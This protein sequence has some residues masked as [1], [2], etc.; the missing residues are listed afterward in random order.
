[1]LGKPAARI[2]GPS[3]GSAEPLDPSLSP[4]P[5]RDEI[6]AQLARILESRIFLQSER[7]RR[8]LR[9]A[10]DLALAGETERIKEYTLGRDV[11]DRDAS[12]DPR[13]DSIVRV[14]ARRLRRKLDEYYRE[15]GAH[16]PVRIEIHQGSYVPLFRYA[17]ATGPTLLPFP[18][19]HARPLNPRTVAVLPFRNLSPDSAQEFFCDG[20]TEEILNTLATIAELNVVARTSVFHFKGVAAD[21]REIGGQLGAGTVIEGSVRSAG[22][23]LR[24][25]AQAIDAGSGVA[26]WSGSF[27]REVTDIFAV[28]DEI[29]R[30]IADSLRVSLGPAH[31]T[32]AR[33]PQ[34]VEAYSAY[35]KGC[36]FWNQVSREGVEAALNEFKRS[37]VLFPDYAP[38]HVGLANAY[39]NLTFWGLLPLGTER[40]KQSALEALRLDQGMSGAY[41]TLGVVSCCESDWE[42]GASLL[43]KA[44]ELQPSNMIARR[45]YAIYLMCFERFAEAQAV[46]ERALELDPLSPYSFYNQGLN[47]YFQ[48]Q[49]ERAIEALEMAVTLEPR[50]R[51][52]QFM[53]A[54]AH[55]HRLDY[56]QAIAHL[57]ELP[58]GPYDATRWGALGEAYARA[59]DRSQAE[60]ALGQLD[61]L[62][63]TGYVSPL[64]RAA[65][66]AGLGHLDRMFEYL[67]EAYQTR[68]PWMCMLKVE[69]RYDPVRSDPRFIYLLERMHLN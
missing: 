30:A 43:R 63:E 39:L 64:H 45:H 38:S 65:I 52:A 51:E 28:Q 21:V 41:A 16:D 13:V 60:M 5:Q 61:V 40:A 29:A 66:R 17:T 11:F 37:I 53:L 20:M 69:P 18:E 3:A 57:L 1:M 44:I 4:N 54:H 12:Y 48:R 7:L 8:F 62:S 68:C 35:L 55:L 42:T 2:P 24:I 46:L 36:H 22:E 9:F 33:G 23:R 27:D 6:E 67:E 14:E 59:G 25:S 50:F 49:Y 15:I 31:E 47:F 56:D 32:A 26:L 34:K 10:V 58:A 19:A